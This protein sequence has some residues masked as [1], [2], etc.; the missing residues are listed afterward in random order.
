MLLHKGKFV[1]NF[2]GSSNNFWVRWGSDGWVFGCLMVVLV[3]TAATGS[4]VGKEEN[5]K[6]EKMMR[7]ILSF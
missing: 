3:V 6:R 5:G 7:A 4:W 1:E 2:F